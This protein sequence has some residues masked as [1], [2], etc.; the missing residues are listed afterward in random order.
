MEINRV[1]RVL[2]LFCLSLVVLLSGCAQ[3]ETAPQQP[4][5]AEKA[6]VTVN[7][8]KVVT[9]S[10]TTPTLQVVVNPPL[11]RGSQIHDRVFQALHDLG[12]D[13]V[14]YVPWLPYPKLGVAELEPPADGKTSWDFSLIDPMM[15][16]FMNAQTGHSVIINFS[17][18]PQWMFKTEKPVPYPA[19]PN[20]VVWDYEK[21]TEFRDPTLKEVGDY[22]ARLVS[23]YTQG[24]FTDEYGKRHDS[25][26]HNKIPIWEVLNEVDFEHNMSPQT[27]TRVYDAIVSAIRRVDPQMKFMGVAL[28]GTSPDIFLQENVPAY[29]EYF[30]NPKNHKPG[31]PLDMVSYHFYTNPSADQSPEVQQYTVFDQAAGFLNSVRYIDAIRQRLSPKTQVDLDELGC[32]PADDNA[33]PRKPIPDSYWNLCGGVYAYLYGELARFGIDVAGESQLVGYP[34]QFPGVSMVDWNNGQPN[35]RFWVLKLLR[36]NFGPGDKLVDTHSGI[37]QVFAQGF[38][39]RDGKRKLLLVNQRDR[40]FELTVPGGSGAEVMYVDQTTG[41]QPPATAHTNGEET[42]LHGLGVAVVTLA[43]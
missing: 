20:Q 2:G 40:D 18:I 31:I 25:S 17:T 4:G 15:E 24:G 33:V 26:H 43:Q 12:A 39:T 32:I 41:F 7:W 8:D 35:A 19:D 1:I 30:L 16:D 36:D 13:D 6:K 27:Y 10:K 23:W 9:V 22:Y 5:A 28:A 38:V 21:G 34:S 14:R 42:T 37:S 3:K 11:R 29:F